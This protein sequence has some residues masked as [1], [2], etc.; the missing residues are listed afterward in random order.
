MK[1]KDLLKELSGLNPNAEVKVYFLR[2]VSYRIY[3]SRIDSC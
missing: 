2:F 3:K 1:V